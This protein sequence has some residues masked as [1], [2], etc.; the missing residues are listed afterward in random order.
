MGQLRKFGRND[1][2]AH[3]IFI[4]LA[5]FELVSHHLPTATEEIYK[6]ETE[7]GKILYF[8][9]FVDRASCNDSW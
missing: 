9:Y 1:D 3:G 5:Y 7:N 6:T 4:P 8:L 2:L